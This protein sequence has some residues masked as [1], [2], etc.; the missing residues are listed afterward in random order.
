MRRQATVGR[1]CSGGYSAVNNGGGG[2][3]GD[4]AM[5]AGS[6]CD[7]DGAKRVMMFRV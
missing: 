2:E 6:G 3:V 4:A 7:N 1:R 5:R